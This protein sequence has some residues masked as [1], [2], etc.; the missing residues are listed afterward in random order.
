MY[1]YKAIV[2]SVYDG[3]TIT[4]S[5]DLGFDVAF[6]TSV[7]LARIN[8]PEVKGVEKIDGLRSRDYVRSLIP[9]GSEVTL[10]TYKDGEEKYGRYLADVF[11]SP[12]VCLNDAIV[13]NGFGQYKEY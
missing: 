13:T 7:R 9:M 8:A 11:L 2:T 5:I 1:E 12:D 10:R 3:D 6:K 4:V